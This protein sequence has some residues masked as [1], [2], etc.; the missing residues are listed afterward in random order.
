[1]HGYWQ[2]LWRTPI[3]L[4]RP[5]RMQRPSA[6]FD[7]KL[8]VAPIL[9]ASV[10]IT[11]TISEWIFCRRITVRGMAKA[12]PLFIIAH[13][14]LA[15]N[16]T[17]SFG[18]YGKGW[19]GLCNVKASIRQRAMQMIMFR[20]FHFAGTRCYPA[21]RACK[22]AGQQYQSSAQTGFARKSCVYFADQEPSC[23]TVD[24]PSARR[25]YGTGDGGESG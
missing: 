1:L 5:N 20:W 4:L 19:T 21:G 24:Y 12:A 9:I 10:S 2:S 25:S 17:S 3:I 13:S 16:A 6:I 11:L 15:V 7:R 23:C 8:S 22:P 18:L 14:M